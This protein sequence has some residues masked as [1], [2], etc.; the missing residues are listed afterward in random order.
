M[1]KGIKKRQPFFNGVQQREY[2]L[3]IYPDTTVYDRIMAEKQRFYMRYGIESVV[4]TFP[5][6]NVAGFSAGEGMDATLIRWLHRI[7]GRHSCFKIVLNNFSGFPHHTIYLRIQHL[8]PLQKLAQELKALDHH[9]HIS[10]LAAG[11]WPH[12]ALASELPEAVYEKAMPVYSRKT[13]HT[14][15][16]A[17]EVVLLAR[18]HPLAAFKTITVFKFLPADHNMAVLL[19]QIS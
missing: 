15:F 5:Y 9:I 7:F 19:N 18:D 16:T 13:F 6:I 1:E 10:S 2:R 12:L 4:K 3:V 17:S 11:R 14:C 8:Q